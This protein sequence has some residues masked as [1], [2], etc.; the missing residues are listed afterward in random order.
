MVHEG[1]QPLVESLVFVIVDKAAIKWTVLLWLEWTDLED[2]ECNNNTTEDDD[3]K[4]NN[5]PKIVWDR[6]LVLPHIAIANSH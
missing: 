6:D 1:N 2:L 4:N 5:P 3:S